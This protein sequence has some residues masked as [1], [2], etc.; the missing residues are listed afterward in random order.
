MKKISAN[1]GRVIVLGK[2]GENLSRCVLFDVSA[3]MELYGDGSVQLVHQRKGDSS[4]YPC[5]VTCK[6]GVARW[7]IRQTDVAVP[8]E[9]MAELQ[10]YQGETIVKSTTYKTLTMP[11]LSQASAAPSQPEQSWVDAVLQAAANV[12]TQV[13]TMGKN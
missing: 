8:G 10:F 7:E 12:V 5:L 3:W 4:P 13:I 2:Q 9:G 6:N 1:P 11:S